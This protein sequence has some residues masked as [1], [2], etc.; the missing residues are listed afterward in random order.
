MYTD[1]YIS[2]I[3]MNMHIVIWRARKYTQA[4]ISCIL[5][6]RTFSCITV[7][8]H[9]PVCVLCSVILCR[10][11]HS[12]YLIKL[13]HVMSLL[14]IQNAFQKLLIVQTTHTTIVQ[15]I[16][17]HPT[18]V[19]LKSWSEVFINRTWFLVQTSI[20]MSKIYWKYTRYKKYRLTWRKSCTHKI[21][22]ANIWRL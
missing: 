21:L 15:Y 3:G 10:S 19:T 22:G 2:C 6:V 16:W 12:Q 7:K 17:P 13:S 5:R 4:C 18:D 8:W 11:A 9:K 14:V 1:V 20:H